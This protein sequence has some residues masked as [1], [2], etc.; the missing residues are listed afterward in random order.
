M[1]HDGFV[2]APDDDGL[3]ALDSR[4]LREVVIDILAS[5]TSSAK[6]HAAASALVFT[7]LMVATATLAALVLVPYELY[8][9][10]KRLAALESTIKSLNERYS[11]QY[12]ILLRRRTLPKGAVADAAASSCRVRPAAAAGAAAGA[13]SSIYS[14][15]SGSAFSDSAY[16]HS[17]Y[18]GSCGGGLGDD[19]PEGPAYYYHGGAQQQQGDE[20]FGTGGLGA[21]GGVLP[22]AGG[23][24]SWDVELQVL[25]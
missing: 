21:R 8:K 4:V 15:G 24:G 3:R 12:G 9:S 16:N 17:A 2:V 5:L 6:S 23:S 11:Q 10:R 13:D 25:Y 14:V 1:T 20:V 22:P 19:A 7:S 18:S